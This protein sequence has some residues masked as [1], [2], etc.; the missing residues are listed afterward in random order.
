MIEKVEFGKHTHPPASLIRLISLREA[1]LLP[2][3]RWE[4]FNT[5]GFPDRDRTCPTSCPIQKLYDQY[6][7][8][9]HNISVPENLSSHILQH[10]K[11]ELLTAHES[12]TCE[13][14][15]I[16]LLM[17]KAVAVEPDSVSSP[18][19]SSLYKMKQHLNL[20]RNGRRYKIIPRH[21]YMSVFAYTT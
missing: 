1:L 14:K 8:G 11:N 7:Q 17:N 18:H 4:W 13:M 21:H 2:Q 19:V 15:S 5:S 6:C 12:P 16:S 20:Q 9:K 3:G 10:D